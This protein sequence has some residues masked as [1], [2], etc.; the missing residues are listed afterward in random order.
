MKKDALKDIVVLDFDG[1]ITDTA[2]Y[3]LNH[4][5]L[6][7]KIFRKALYLCLTQK[8]LEIR[9]LIKN[10]LMAQSD[11][12]NEINK[13]LINFRDKYL[14]DF[15]LGLK[16]HNYKLFIVSSSPSKLIENF[17]EK[18]KVRMGDF[19]YSIFASSEENFLTT[20]GKL[21]IIAPYKDRIL[22]SVVDSEND[23]EINKLGVVRFVKRNFLW[24]ISERKPTGLYVKN[25]YKPKNL[26]KIFKER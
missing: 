14:L 11:Y 19:S 9:N 24:Y 26:L 15:L 23:Y 1:V 16:N 21:N 6:F 4:P 25:L 20:N 8:N 13:D 17:F 5:I 18:I 22:F 12:S 7:L 2:L 10:F 3:Y